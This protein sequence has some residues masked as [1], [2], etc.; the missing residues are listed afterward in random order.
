[1][2]GTWANGVTIEALRASVERHDAQLEPRSRG[3]SW[4]AAVAVILCDSP[5]EAGPELLFME[6]ASRNDDP[7]SGQM[8]FPGGRR[9]AGD[10]DLEVTAARET[11]EEV[12]VPLP[13]AIGRL[14]EL[15]NNRQAQRVGGVGRIVVA[16][17]VYH[18]RERP[19]VR[20]NYEVAS[21]MWIPLEWIL[22]ADSAATYELEHG[23][24]KA[25]F[26]ALV[27]ERYKV[28]GLTYRILEGLVELVGH[29]LPARQVY[30]GLK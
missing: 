27:Y 18:L 23:D 16:P 15:T 3:V 13:A 5:G 8:A 10:R 12:G 14:D 17:Y 19:L 7:W 21:A 24:Y 30:A 11:L 9:D 28:W 26:P 29:Q 22:H 6:R 1:M 20:P 25:T 4:E 2:T